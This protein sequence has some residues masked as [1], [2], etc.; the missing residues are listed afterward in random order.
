[1]I[2][3]RERVRLS[4]NHQEA[5]RVPF[6]LG[7]GV[8]GMTVIPYRRLK[9]HLGIPGEAGN[10]NRDWLIMTD[11]DEVLLQT[12]DIDT[13]RIY[14]GA[15]KGW[16]RQYNPDGTWRDILGILRKPA[17]YY[18]EM[19]DCPLRGTGIDAID[20]YPWPDYTDPGLYEGLEEKVKQLYFNTDYALV[21]PVVAGGIF[22]TAMW[23]RGAEDFL[24]D[25][26]QNKPFAR[27]LLG[28][29]LEIHTGYLDRYLAIVGPY[30]EIMEYNDDFGT[31]RGLMIS[32]KLYREMIKPFH[33]E[34]VGF[35]KSRTKAKVFQH[36]CGSVYDLVPELIEIGVDILNPLQ[37]KAVGNDSFRLKKEFGDR[38]V[39]HGGVDTQ[40]VMPLGTVED[41]EREVRTRLTAFAPGGGYIFAASQNIQADVPPENV[42][43]MFNVARKWGRYPIQKLHQNDSQLTS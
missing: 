28:K 9:Q 17:S 16:T 37:P 27:K 2:T 11:Y 32:P 29:L 4:L 8:A 6:D 25:L 23:L 3:H 13:R 31:Q 12:L 35:I 15:P 14:M 43:A 39:F 26:L 19:A 34:L 10:F 42:V 41:V 33:K 5:D 21:G 22:E 30:I 38:L 40:E 1:M 18:I 36:T 20:Q 24:V 7:G